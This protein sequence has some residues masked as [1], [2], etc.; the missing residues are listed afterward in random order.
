MYYFWLLFIILIIIVIIIYNK[1]KNIKINEKFTVLPRRKLDLDST[2]ARQLS[3]DN[4][5]AI[6]TKYN[7]ELD[8]QFNIIDN[9]GKY[10]ST[11]LEIVAL[12][13]QLADIN[14]KLMLYQQK[15][16]NYE[17]NSLA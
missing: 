9:V 16:P 6:T 2:L 17:N 7:N 14:K 15:L 12:E 1:Y 4:N 10:K 3:D 5:T 8:L 13:K 11:E